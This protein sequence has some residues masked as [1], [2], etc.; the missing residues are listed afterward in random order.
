VAIKIS[1]IIPLYNVEKYIEACVDS[2]CQQKFTDFEVIVIDDGSKDDSVENA[3]RAFKNNSKEFILIT[4]DNKGQ[5]SARNEGIKIAQGEYI[6]FVD[7]DDTID[8]RYLE[9]LYNANVKN[10]TI[11]SCCGFQVVGTD[12]EIILPAKKE[13]ES[14][15]I[16]SRSEILEKFLNREIIV[17]TP[18]ILVKKEL[19]KNN[20]LFFDETALYSEDDHHVWKVLYA[21]ENC[22]II[23][24]RL[25]NYFVRRNSIMTGSSAEKMLTGYNSFKKL[26]T[27]LRDDFAKKIMA[28]WVFSAL[29]AASRPLKYQPYKHFAKGVEYKVYIPQMLKIKDKRIKILTIVLRYSLF[30]F[31]WI[32]KLEFLGNVIGK[33]RGHARS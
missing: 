20:S 17:L 3:K 26:T 10:Q 29:R 13:I 11:L 7:S 27:E 25:Y 4:Q 5:A 30:S 9:A 33:L 24:A 31:Y 28:R 19:I 22:S 15:F 21:I 8:S 16:L 32:N 6:A 2:I 12:Q 1:V 14:D 23:P 18:G